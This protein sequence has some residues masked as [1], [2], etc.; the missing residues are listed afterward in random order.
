METNYLAVGEV[1]SLILEKN[2]ELY[3]CSLHL[4][5][6]RDM[7]ADILQSVFLKFL[8]MVQKGRIKRQ[9]AVGYL[10]RMVRN[11]SITEWRRRQRI[12]RLPESLQ[13]A[14]P[15]SQLEADATVENLRQIIMDTVN[16]SE[17]P[18]AMREA[19]RLRYLFQFDLDTI[20]QAVGKSRSSV[21]RLLQ[22]G[23]RALLAKFEAAGYD[24]ELLEGSGNE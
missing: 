18:E 12:V 23:T 2:S 10:V 6:D 13:F 11:E 4:C 20:A 19:L 9:G 14:K 22:R 17:L 7:A 3:T 24:S 1:E 15:A 21:S 16:D 5:R 8:T